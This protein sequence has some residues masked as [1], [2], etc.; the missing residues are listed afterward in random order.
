MVLLT[1]DSVCASGL[2]FSL[3]VLWCPCAR[4]GVQNGAAGRVTLGVG[5]SVPSAPVRCGVWGWSGPRADPM[6]C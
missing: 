2:T 6:H 1:F 4:K 3:A 5:L